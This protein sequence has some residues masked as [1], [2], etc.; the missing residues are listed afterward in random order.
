MVNNRM[1][2][3]SGYTLFDFQFMNFKLNFQKH[4]KIV[5]KGVEFS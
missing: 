5:L 3:C 4:L 1:Y 2:D